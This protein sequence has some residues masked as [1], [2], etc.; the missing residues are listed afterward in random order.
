MAQISKSVATLRIIG[1]DLIPTEISEVLNCEATYE[2]IKGDII[3]GNETRRQQVVEVGMWR[4]QASDYAPENLN[5]QISEVLE[6]L[7]TDLNVW[8]KLSEKYYIDFFCGLFMERSNEAMDIS[9]S[10]LKALGE[11]GIQLSLDI[12]YE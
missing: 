4:L 7:S 2:Q 6:K 5:A 3:A 11:R 9:P 10:L 1:D 8:Q 12:Y